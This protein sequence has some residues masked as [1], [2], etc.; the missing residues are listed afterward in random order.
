MKVTLKQIKDY[1]KEN[2]NWDKTISIGKIDNDKE[3][4]ICFYNSGNRYYQ[5]VIGGINCKS[6]YIKPITILLRYTKNKNSAETLIQMP[7]KRQL[8]L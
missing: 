5:P 1:F 6:T 8:P 2:F 3:E 4:A 7:F